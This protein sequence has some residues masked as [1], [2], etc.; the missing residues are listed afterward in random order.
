MNDLM[1][2]ALY[3]ANHRI[4]P[5]L[6][7]SKISKKIYEFVGPICESTDKFA[8]VKKFQELKEKDLIVM[9][10]VGAYGMSL[11]S[12]YNIRPK[13]AEVLVKGS[14]VIIIK[15]RQKLRELI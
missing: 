7:K 6:K 15:K 3:G 10:D 12:N 13:P 5:T 9:R 4:L 2:P 14:R 11:S 1:R 8:T